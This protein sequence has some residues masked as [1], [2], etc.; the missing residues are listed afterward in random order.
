MDVYIIASINNRRF[1]ENLLN[2]IDGV[3]IVQNGLEMGNSLKTTLKE[4]MR[5]DGRIN[6]YAEADYTEGTTAY[7]WICNK[8]TEFAERI[9]KEEKDKIAKCAAIEVPKHLTE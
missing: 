4:E 9:R 1:A 5:A 3:N 7:M 2:D 8:I 6:M